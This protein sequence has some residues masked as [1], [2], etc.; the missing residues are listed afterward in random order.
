MSHLGMMVILGM[1]G[2]NEESANAMK[3]ALGKTISDIELT[4][5]A[6]FITFVDGYKIKLSDEGQ[7]CCESR[8]MYSDDGLSWFIGSKLTDAE[9][10]EAPNIEDEWGAHEVAFLVVTTSKG[11]FTI[12]THNKHN[13]YY[14]GFLVRCAIVED[15]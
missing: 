13:G 14:G 9:V 5:E 3:R 8:Y 2:G 4:E 1:M 7:T 6:L 11:A 15:V 10:K 12:E